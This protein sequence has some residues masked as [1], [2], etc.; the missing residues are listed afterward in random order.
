[1]LSSLM[2]VI[3]FPFVWDGRECQ[4]QGA[5]LKAYPIDKLCDTDMFAVEMNISSYNTPT[6]PH[7]AGRAEYSLVLRNVY[8]FP[9]GVP[10]FSSSTYFFTQETQVSRKQPSESEG[11]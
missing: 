5:L 6:R 11:K 1:M 2:L 8:V 3:L 9:E 7:S 10:N 4:G